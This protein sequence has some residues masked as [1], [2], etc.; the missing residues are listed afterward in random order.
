MFAEDFRSAYDGVNAWSNC[1]WLCVNGDADPITGKIRQGSLVCPH[2]RC[3]RRE[4]AS[5]TLICG[6]AHPSQA[7]L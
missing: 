2:L 4:I 3:A 7:S 5:S 6:G 1:P